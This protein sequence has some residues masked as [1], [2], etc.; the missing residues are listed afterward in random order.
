MHIVSS[1]SEGWN[2][3]RNDCTGIY[4]NHLGRIRSGVT[5]MSD[6]NLGT[7]LSHVWSETYKTEFHSENKEF[8]RNKSD[9]K[10]GRVGTSWRALE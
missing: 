6:Q 7:I 2:L 5:D 4:G 10:D 9:G 1:G 8:R 3:T